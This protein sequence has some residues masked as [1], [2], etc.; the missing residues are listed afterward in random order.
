MLLRAACV[1]RGS[2]LMR[3]GVRMA[4]TKSS[5]AVEAGQAGVAVAAEVEDPIHS[6]DELIK[7]FPPAY[8]KH[9]IEVLQHLPT[10]KFIEESM[11]ALHEAT[12]SPWWAVIAA[13]TLGMRV[14][15]L[16]FQ[17][18]LQRNTNRLEKLQARSTWR[19]GG[20]ARPPRAWSTRDP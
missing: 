12:G 13:C 11:V 17:A 6:L 8:A 19:C 10:V 2:G 3:G 9:H 15:A 5:V 20:R 7:V 1:A 14:I 18:L 16:P 4:S